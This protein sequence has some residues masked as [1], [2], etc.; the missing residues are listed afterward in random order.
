MRRALYILLA[1][2]LLPVLAVAGL[3]VFLNTSTGRHFAEDEI[4]RLAA[5]GVRI[6]GLAG[7][8]PADIK[9][10]DLS[11][12]DRNGTWLTGKGLELRWRP[13]QLLRGDVAIDVLTADTLAIAREPVS[14]GKSGDTGT[15]LPPLHAEIGRLKIGTLSLSPELA[16]EAVMLHV[17]GAGKLRGPANVTLALDAT[18]PDGTAQYHLTAALAPKSSAFSLHISEPPGGLLGHF[19]GPSVSAPLL[20]DAALSGPSDKA[21]LTFS[22]ALGA[23][24]LTGAGTLGLMPRH[25]F[26]DVTLTVPD[27]TPFTAMADRKLGGTAQLHLTV[28]GQGNGNATLALEGTAAIANPPKPLAKLLGAKESLSMRA[29]LHGKEVTLDAFQLTG[30]VFAATA[31]GRIAPSGVDLFTSVEL[32]DISALSPGI[33]GQIR[34]SGHITGNA[35]DYA[36]EA[37]LAG[38]VAAPEVRSGP[39]RIALSL[40]HLPRAPTGTLTGSG[41]LENSPLTLDA[42]LTRDASGNAALKITTA[43]WRSLDAVAD[44]RLPPGEPLPTGT[45]TIAIAALQDI[46]PFLPLKL[47]GSA[48]L[49]LAHP[50]AQAFTLNL[51]ATRLSGLPRLGAID[52]TLRAQ[53]PEDALAL[54]AQL[55]CTSLYAAPASASLAATL[56]VPARSARL[57]RFNASWHGLEPALL[58]PAEIAAKVGLAIRHLSLA[59]AGGRVA[60]DGALTPRLAASAQLQNLPL[61]VVKLFAPSLDA[62]GYVSATAN[63][64]GT[65]ASPSGK[66]TLNAQ[67]L[68]LRNGS[69]AALPPASLNGTATLN[70]GLAN[71]DLA[72]NAGPNLALTA[73]GGVPLNASNGLDLGLDGT[74]DLRLLDAIIGAEGTTARGTATAHLRLTGPLSSPSANGT[75]TLANGSVQ[76]IGTGLNLT[77]IQAR[78]LAQGQSL[79]LQSVTAQAGHGQITGHGTLDLSPGMPVDITLYADNA[80]PT[81]SDL[82][83]ETLDGGLALKGTLQGQMALSG[84]LTITR[85]AINIPRALPPSVARLPI[86]LA[87]E[88]PAPPPA[89]PPPIALALD[90]TARDQIFVR[91]DG[92]FA[93]L[94]G[95]VTLGGT[96]AAPTPEGGFDL[97]RGEYTLAGK[98][99]QFTQGRISF[100]GAGVVPALDLEATTTTP[101]GTTATLIVGGTANKPSITLTS[102]PP[103][104]SDEI[105]SRLLFGVGTSSLS[106]FQ[107][108]S[109]AAALA[110]LSGVGAGLN[111][112]DKMRSVLGLD[113]LSIGNSGPSGLPSL[114]AGRYVA[115]GVFVGASQATNGLGTQA[116]VQ[117]N[118]YKGLKLQSSTGTS[119]TGGGQSSSVGLTYQYNY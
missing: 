111:P 119:A 14:S 43:R 59:L 55:Q 106:A 22:A 28:A 81:T 85:A 10:A 6:A 13:L 75:L 21:A 82:V 93:V 41:A 45:A 108:A 63:L 5:P 79:T 74:V 4:N 104:P 2:L 69:A 98:T 27:L 46:S 112:L 62:T 11:L 47:G 3:A 117:I 65:L 116:N 57:T 25:P 87:G 67:G 9:L 30:P 89:P 64:T 56:N 103:L 8:F 99:L 23:A 20:A 53:G 101:D 100:T 38:N 17:T 34:E 40:Q 78:F 51:T 31:S 68:H 76:N 50:N 77:H 102:S 7:H 86:I 32:S 114:Q 66:L 52:G 118:L 107:A 70:P 58:G 15:N 44:L 94:G 109:L 42:A 72:L 24:R 110:Q 29:R 71:V 91:G 19:A 35:G 49:S 54:Q 83:T 48:R 36:L 80:T 92:L 95:H 12:A 39:F 1:L 33:S 88:A 84:K 96:V 73:R 60:L 26:A 105:L 97:I 90:I 18:T 115:P 113:E 61:S 37:Q 16:G